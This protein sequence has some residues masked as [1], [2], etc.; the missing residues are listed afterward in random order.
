M[1]DAPGADLVRDIFGG[2]DGEARADG[3]DLELF[4]G[5]FV[6]GELASAL[7]LLSASTEEVGNVTSGDVSDWLR[8]WLLRC[9]VDVGMLPLL[10][11][12]DCFDWHPAVV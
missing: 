2:D 5:G 6:S 3:T 4:S 11:A 10:S 12:F 7:V 8:A 9:G 1:P